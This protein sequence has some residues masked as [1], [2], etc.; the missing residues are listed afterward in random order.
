MGEQIDIIVQTAVA[1][2]IVSES[3]K[4]N[5]GLFSCVK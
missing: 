5:L 2:V 4:L 1:S 3:Q